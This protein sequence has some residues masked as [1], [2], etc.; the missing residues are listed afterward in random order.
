MLYKITEYI[1]DR[2]LEN[3][4]GR[5]LE[6]MLENMMLEDL[7]VIKCIDIMM[8]IIRNKIIYFSEVGFNRIYFYLFFFCGVILI[9]RKKYLK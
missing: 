7:P 8:G 4:L 2:V 5:K 1:S 9:I 3:I 6:D